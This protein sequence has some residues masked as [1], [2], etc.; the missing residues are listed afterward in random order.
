MTPAEHDT[1]CALVSHLPHALASVFLQTVMAKREEAVRFGGPSFR[2]ITRIAG[3]SPKVWSDIFLTNRRLPEVLRAFVGNLER[4]LILLESGDAEKMYR[5]L[6]EV[7]SLKERL[8]HE[9]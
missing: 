7:A 9:P 4:F 2:D 3:S 1:I 6:E 8:H 5:F